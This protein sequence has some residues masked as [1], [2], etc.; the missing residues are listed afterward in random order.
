MDSVVEPGF[1]V[2]RM[3]KAPRHFEAGTQESG[4]MRGKITPAALR[5]EYGMEEIPHV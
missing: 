3:P 2:Q 4:V 5:C 1:H